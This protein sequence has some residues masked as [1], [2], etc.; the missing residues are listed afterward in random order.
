MRELAMTAA[1]GG[2]LPTMCLQLAEV[3]ANI[4]PPDISGTLS[5]PNAEEL[6]ASTHT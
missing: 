6:S 5:R 3:F 4:R 1:S 2:K